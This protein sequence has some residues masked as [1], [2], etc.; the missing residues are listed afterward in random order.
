MGESNLVEV[1]WRKENKSEVL[2]QDALNCVVWS[3]TSL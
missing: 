1:K 3:A 2:P